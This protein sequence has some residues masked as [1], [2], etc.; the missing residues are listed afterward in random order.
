MISSDGPI[1]ISVNRPRIE[2]FVPGSWLLPGSGIEQRGIGRLRR[3]GGRRV[4]RYGAE[5][6]QRDER[7]DAA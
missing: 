5:R 1:V 2:R 4:G 3:H 7:E 6:E